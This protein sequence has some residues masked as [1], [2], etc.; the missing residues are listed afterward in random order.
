MTAPATSMSAQEAGVHARRTLPGRVS[1]SGVEGP[2]ALSWDLLALC[3]WW[4]QEV[5]VASHL[6]AW[7]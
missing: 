2:G 3:V 5:T 7:F 4:H 1:R 6:P